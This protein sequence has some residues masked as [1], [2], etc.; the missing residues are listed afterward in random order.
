MADQAEIGNLTYELL[1]R[2]SGRFDRFELEL[3]DVKMR[4]ASLDDHV[5][6]LGVSVTGL[7]TRMDRVESRLDRIERRLDLVDAH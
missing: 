1:K 7:T 6:G 4:L 3:M 2:M 5:S